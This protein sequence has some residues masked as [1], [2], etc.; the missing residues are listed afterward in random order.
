MLTIMP[1]VAA[2]V[3]V[4]LSSVATLAQDYPRRPLRLIAPFPS[5]GGV[6]FLA[7]IVG[8]KMTENWD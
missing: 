5:G 3:V 7:R 8:Q 2:A 6:D 1:A 4:S